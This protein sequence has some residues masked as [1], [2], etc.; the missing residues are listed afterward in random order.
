MVGDWLNKLRRTQASTAHTAGVTGSGVLGA[1]ARNGLKRLVTTAF[2]N[3]TTPVTG[4]ASWAV[5]ATGTTAAALTVCVVSA[6]LAPLSVN[7][8]AVGTAADSATVA[9]GFATVASTS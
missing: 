2:R 4:V 6:L 5:G 7:A 3:P 9:D 1:G 8:C